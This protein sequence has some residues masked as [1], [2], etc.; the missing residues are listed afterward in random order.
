MAAKKTGVNGNC[1]VFSEN[2]QN[3]NPPVEQKRWI[4]C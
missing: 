1:P 3:F 2:L 4:A